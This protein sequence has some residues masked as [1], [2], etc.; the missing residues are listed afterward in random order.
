MAQEIALLMGGT[1]SKTERFQDTDQNNRCPKEWGLGQTTSLG[2]LKKWFSRHGPKQCIGLG[3][4]NHQFGTPKKVVFWTRPKT[5]G[6][7][8]YVVWGGQTPSLGH[9]KKVIF[10]TR[11]KTIGVRKY[12]VWGGQ[13]PSLGHL[14]KVIFKTRPKTI[15]VR[16]YV[17]WGGQTPSLGHLK[18]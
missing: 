1:L 3:R 16:N 2:H 7:R 15:G 12:V 11:P 5:I 17:V 14:K 8:K 13:T 4:A 18:K 9:L 6:V 10:K